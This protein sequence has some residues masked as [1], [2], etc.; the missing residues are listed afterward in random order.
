MSFTA[1]NPTQFFSIVGPAYVAENH[2]GLGHLPARSERE[3]IRLGVTSLWVSLFAS[4]GVSL[5]GAGHAAKAVQIDHQ[6]LALNR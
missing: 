6:D 5:L 4:F 1:S 2:E 3:Q